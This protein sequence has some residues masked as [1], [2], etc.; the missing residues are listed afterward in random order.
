MPLRLTAFYGILHLEA[1]LAIDDRQNTEDSRIPWHPAFF[2]AIQQELK[3]YKDVLQFE[4]EYQ[5]TAEPLKIDVVI[6]KKIKDVV[7]E[8]NIAAIFREENLLEYKS[9]TDHVSIA[10]FY[11][12][13]GYACLY[14]SSKEIPVTSLTLTFVESRYP[15]VLTAHLQEIRGYSIE[16]RQPGIYTV[17]GDI[18]PIQIIDNRRLSA[19]ENVWLKDLDNELDVPGISRIAAEIHR[20]GKSARIKAYLDA[21]SRANPERIQ[22]AINMSKSGLTIEQVFENVGWIAKW[23]ERK[24]FE[25][26][27]N[28]ITIGMPLESIA[29]ATTLDVETV[30]SLAPAQA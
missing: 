9:P 24:A 16:E 26:A 20:L 19:E 27:R 10:D 3:Q 21:I 23:E 4:S 25:I 1:F 7:I 11:K 22:E 13:Y 5:L 30:R 8:K 12:V 15:R 29:K 17:E 2:E 28:L 6:I 14:A 18:I